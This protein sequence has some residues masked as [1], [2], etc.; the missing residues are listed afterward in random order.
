VKASVGNAILMDN[1]AAAAFEAYR[2]GVKPAQVN[3]LLEMYECLGDIDKFLVFL[4]YQASRGLWGRGNAARRLYK[5][6]SE[7][8]DPKKVREILTIFKWIY[9]SCQRR[10]PR[11]PFPQAEPRGF[12]KTLLDSL[13][14]R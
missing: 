4:A 1:I 10:R 13:M 2:D 11:A 12:L 8:R 5:I 7:N 3:K 6:L 14:S 9:E